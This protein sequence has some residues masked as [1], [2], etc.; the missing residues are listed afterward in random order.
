MPTSNYPHGF[1]NGVTIHEFPYVDTQNANG[2]VFWVDSVKGSNGNK[3]TFKSPFA[4][5][6]Y[7]VG[8]C[9][10]NQGDKIY[11]AAGHA[12]TII[13]ATGLVA[14]VAGI[15]IIGL[16]NGTN[17][18]TLTFATSTAAS[19]VV[20][21]ANV[22]ISNIRFIC[23]IASQVTVIDCNSTGTTISDCYFAEG[24]ATGL[25]F[26]DVNGGA[27]NACDGVQVVNCEFSNPT[28][29]NYNCLLYTSPSPRDA[30]LS[31][32]PSSAWTRTVD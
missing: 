8:R 25:T 20:S 22:A 4:T 5:I 6:D 23:N 15:S 9:T 13:A 31:R 19:V 32:M 28:A 10:A 30:T 3:G 7:A 21:A 2:N 14:D 11:V 1:A 18:P 27:A 26:I 29:G 24:S 16:G 12:E 17:R